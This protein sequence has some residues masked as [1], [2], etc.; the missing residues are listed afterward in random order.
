MMLKVVHGTSSRILVGVTG[1][2][3]GIVK[4][5][6]YADNEASSPSFTSV[7]QTLTVY[8]HSAYC[9]TQTEMT[10]TG[11]A[12]DAPSIAKYINDSVIQGEECIDIR[13]SNRH[14]TRHTH[15]TVTPAKS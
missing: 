5:V 2:K 9:S 4:V 10:V 13:V 11:Y 6:T 12:P 1:A 3:S 14:T 7:V 15:L 8:S